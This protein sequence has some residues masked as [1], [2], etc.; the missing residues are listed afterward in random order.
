[1]MQGCVADSAVE[2]ARILCH[3]QPADSVPRYPIEDFVHDDFI[4]EMERRLR[5]I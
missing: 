1:M 3:W 4:V 5:T 2:A